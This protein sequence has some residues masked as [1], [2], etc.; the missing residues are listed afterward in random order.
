MSAA[1]LGLR[2][3]AELPAELHPLIKSQP[4]QHRLVLIAE[5]FIQLRRLRS[6]QPL[7]LAFKRARSAVRRQTQAQGRWV[8]IELADEPS[9]LLTAL[10][11][12]SPLR[13]ADYVRRVMDERKCSRRRAEQLLREIIEQHRQ[14]QSDLFLGDENEDGED[15]E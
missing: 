8:P 13:Y 1:S 3:L 11:D 7:E 10:R 9:D 5:T 2:A 4:A 12:P 6:G 15:E 14:G